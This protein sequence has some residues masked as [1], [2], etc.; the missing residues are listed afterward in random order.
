MLLLASRAS[1]A[2]S[3]T[4]YLLAEGIFLR[5]NPSSRSSLRVPQSAFAFLGGD[6]ANGASFKY[7]QREL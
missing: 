4:T 7:N 3:Q 6:K 2:E 1:W 5:T